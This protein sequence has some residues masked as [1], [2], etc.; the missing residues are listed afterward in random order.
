ML[1]DIEVEHAFADVVDA[2]R[3]Q[4]RMA[5]LKAMARVVV[6]VRM[7]ELERCAEIAEDGADLDMDKV[8]LCKSIAA[9]I[10]ARSDFNT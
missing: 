1:V 7:D 6:A 5:L 9:A 8:L 3:M 2:S 10:R 4:D